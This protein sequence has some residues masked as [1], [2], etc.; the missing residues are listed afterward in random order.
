MPRFVKCY[1]TF[2]NFAHPSGFISLTYFSVTNSYPG[3]NLANKLNLHVGSVL[4]PGNFTWSVCVKKYFFCRKA[5]KLH[6]QVNDF[7]CK[8]TQ[9]LHQTI[10][11][12]SNIYVPRSIEVLQNFFHYRGISDHRC[13]AV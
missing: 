10:C 11:T 9:V 2:N 12:R 7:S 3:F 4:F 5:K 13:P 1:N 8:P 6:C